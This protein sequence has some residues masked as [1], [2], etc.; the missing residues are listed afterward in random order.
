M[1]GPPTTLPLAM[2]TVFQQAPLTLTMPIPSLS[3]IRSFVR[4]LFDRTHMNAECVII[5]L[6]YVERLID[7]TNRPLTA[8]N[9][10]PIVTA[11]LLSAKKFWDDHSTYNA[12]FAALLPIFS[13]ARLNALEVMFL[14]DLKYSLYISASEYARYYFALRAMR[15]RVAMSISRYSVVN[16]EITNVTHVDSQHSKMHHDNSKTDQE[17][18]IPIV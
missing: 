16:G 2:F 13:L 18:H 5:A 3:G 11:A 10:L 9:W 17:Q 1:I 7:M 4:R 6:I 14:I 8:R 15:R 12:D